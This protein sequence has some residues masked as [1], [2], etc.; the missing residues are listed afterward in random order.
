MSDNILAFP[1][2]LPDPTPNGYQILQSPC[3]V[4]TTLRS[5]GIISARIRS[6]GQK[7][8]NVRYI[9]TTIEYHNF[10]VFYHDTDFGVNPFTINLLIGSS[11]REFTVKFT[12]TPGFDYTNGNY[13]DVTCSYSEV[14]A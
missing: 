7:T 2:Y 3:D 13:V 4:I 8:F 10:V 12:G 14:L 11:F 1:P 5:N 6:R 9:F